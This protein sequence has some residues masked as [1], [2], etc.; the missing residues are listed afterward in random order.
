MQTRALV[1]FGEASLNRALRV[2]GRIGDLSFFDGRYYPSKAP[3][4]SFAAVPIY[5]GLRALNGG[6]VGSVPELPLVFMGRLFLTVLPTLLSLILVRRFLA[7]YLSDSIADSLTIFYALGTL[8]LSYSLLFMS[9]QTTATLLFAAFFLVWRWS[10]AE[11]PQEALLAAGVLGGLAVSAEY[12]S[13]LPAG[14]LALYV[15]L[16]AREQK[17]PWRNFSLGNDLPYRPG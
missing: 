10:R 6:R 15:L 9:H 5:A 4:L 7:T 17:R 14:L 3:L 2:Y 11:R 1:D 8:A 12:T 16:G 13:A